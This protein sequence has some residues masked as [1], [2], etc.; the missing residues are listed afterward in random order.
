MHTLP[1]LQSVVL[2]VDDEDEIRQ[3]VADILEDEGYQ[4]IG[5]RNGLEALTYLQNAAD[6]PC[7]ILLDLM[8]PV[9]DGQRFR[10]EQQHDVRLRDIPVVVFSAGRTKQHAVTLSPVAFIDKPFDYDLL[11]TT[12][13][14]YSGVR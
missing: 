7:L 11:C 12:I 4:V 13:A 9:M 8:M 14:T 2:V 3:L 10:S 6:L 1:C 5:A